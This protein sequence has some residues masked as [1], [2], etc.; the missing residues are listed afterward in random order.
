MSKKVLL[1]KDLEMDAMDLQSFLAEV[2]DIGDDIVCV[3]VQDEEGRTFN[4][5]RLVQETLTDGS[6]V[7]NIVLSEK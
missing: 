3:Y 5:A 7:Y 4:H 1:S 2:F 6:Y